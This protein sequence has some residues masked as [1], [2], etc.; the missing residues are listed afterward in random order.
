MQRARAWHAVTRAVAIGALVLQLVLVLQGGR[1]LDEHQPAGSGR[2]AR[3]SGRR[4]SRSRATSW[5]RSPRCSSPATR[6]RDGRGWRALRL[7]ARR[8][9]HRHRRRALLPAAAAARPRRRRLRRRQAAAH[10]R[11]GPRGRRLGGCSARG[12]RIDRPRHRAGACAGRSPG[13]PG[14]WSSGGLTGWY[15]YPFLDHREPEGVAAWSSPASG[16]PCSSCSAVLGWRR[17][18]RP[19]CEGGSMTTASTPPSPR[20]APAASSAT[21]PAAGGCTCA[22]APQ[23]GHVGCCDTSPGAAR[24]RAL[25]RDRPPGRPELRARRGLVLGLRP[26]R[27]AC[28]A[29]RSL[30]RPAVP[31]T[32]PCPGPAGPRARR[33]AGPHPLAT[34]GPRRPLRSGRLSDRLEEGDQ[35]VG[36]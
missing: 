17:L 30:R 9:H 5:S 22:A 15:P 29:R 11:A 26:G 12:P 31:R 2:P 20:A 14:R 7:A 34:A 1:V 10:G 27:R 6:P 33:L 32:S 21:P 28:S 4:T 35:L 19:P 36:D 18:V 16:S 23:C 25:P 13:S 24:H 3:T 8:R